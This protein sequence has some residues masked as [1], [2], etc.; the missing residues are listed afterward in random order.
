MTKMN[1]PFPALEPFRFL[2]DDEIRPFW[3]D[4]RQD[5]TALAAVLAPGG[6]AVKE[7]GSGVF[8]VHEHT[9]PVNHAEIILGVL[10]HCWVRTD[11]DGAQES[12]RR[13]TPDEVAGWVLFSQSKT[14]NQPFDVKVNY[15]K[16]LASA[17]A[18][19]NGNRV[20]GVAGQTF[21]PTDLQEVSQLFGVNQNGYT[22]LP[23]GSVFSV[24]FQLMPQQPANAAPVAG[25]QYGPPFQM[26]IGAGDPGWRI[27]FAGAAVFG[28]RLPQVRYEALLRAR[29]IGDLE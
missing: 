10:P 14:N 1:Q 26:Q 3:D 12:V 7:I 13:M 11:V 29:R 16:A 17:S 18:K 6:Q 4:Q 2:V 27:D 19:N 23:A 8:V 21:I 9:V 24:R 22:Y 15:N 20:E 25:D 5:L 28:L